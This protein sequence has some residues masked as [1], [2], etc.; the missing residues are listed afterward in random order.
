MTDSNILASNATIKK[1]QEEVL[2]NTKG[3]YTK[4]E[5][6]THAGSANLK[7]LQRGIL[8]N[9]KKLHMKKSI[10]CLVNANMGSKTNNYQYYDYVLAIRALTNIL[11]SNA[12][13]KKIQ[14][15]VLFN[16]KGQY[17]KEESNTHA[18]SANLKQLQRGILLNTKKLHMKK[19]IICLVN[20]NM[21]SK[22]N[23]YQYYDYVLAIR[24]LTYICKIMSV[25]K[26]LG[27]YV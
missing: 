26:I 10:I 13:I 2:F 27:G 19:S 5:S 7:Q 22:T 15:E 18:G 9:T 23:N 6:N 11:A 24:A 16:T 8:L 12:T 1:S 4:E 17:T 14:E 20:A 21:G 3:Q 25:K